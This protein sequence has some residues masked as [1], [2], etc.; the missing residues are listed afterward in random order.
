MDGLRVLRPYLSEDECHELL[1]LLE[2]KELNVRVDF[3]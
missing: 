1:E 2:A 3:E